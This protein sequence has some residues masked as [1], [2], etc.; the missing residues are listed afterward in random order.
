MGPGIEGGDTGMAALW[1]GDD[2]CRGNGVKMTRGF[3]IKGSALRTVF[4]DGHNETVCA[5]QRARPRDRLL[6]QLQQLI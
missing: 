3:T 6:D 5:N 2:A 1:Y 4:H